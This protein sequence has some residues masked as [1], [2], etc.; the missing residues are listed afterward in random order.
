MRISFTGNPSDYGEIP[1]IMT[2]PV[3]L[4][5]LVAERHHLIVKPLPFEPSLT[6]TLDVCTLLRRCGY[7]I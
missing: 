7:I 4:A 2:E 1:L 6:G 3:G 5:Y